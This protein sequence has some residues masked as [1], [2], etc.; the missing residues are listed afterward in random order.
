MALD[1]ANALVSLAEA[2]TYLKITAT[3]ENSVIEDFINRA[4]IWANNYTGRLLLSRTNTE[5]FDGDGTNSLQLNNYPISSVVY[6]RE[7]PLRVFGSDTNIESEDYFYDDNNGTIYLKNTVFQ[8]GTKTVY[9]VYIGGY[10]TVP[11]SIKEAV[12]LYVGSAYRREYAD[13]R[14]GVSSETVG[15]RTTTYATA[16]I[17]P[18]A[19]ALLDRYVSNKVLFGGF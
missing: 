17:P 8:K 7:D 13:Q 2:K 4:S 11:E 6:L 18:K 19:K 16:D 3:S 14:F 12:L 15:D 5:K 9:V 1:T 10:T